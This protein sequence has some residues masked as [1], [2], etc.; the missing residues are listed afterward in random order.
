MQPFAALQDRLTAWRERRL[1]RMLTDSSCA[2]L[3]WVGR[4]PIRTNKTRSSRLPS[5]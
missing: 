4:L 3:E 1:P 5:A 2:A